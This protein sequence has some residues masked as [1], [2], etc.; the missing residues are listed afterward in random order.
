MCN[1]VVS[2]VETSVVVILASECFLCVLD[3]VSGAK[4]ISQRIRD[5]HAGGRNS[6]ISIIVPGERIPMRYGEYRHLKTDQG[7]LY[8]SCQVVWGVSRHVIRDSSEKLQNG[9]KEPLPVGGKDDK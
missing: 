4:S 6:D 2:R 9:E 8:G 7:I 1:D 3:Q 5:W